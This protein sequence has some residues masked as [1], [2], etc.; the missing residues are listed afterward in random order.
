MTAFVISGVAGTGKSTIAAA[1]AA[2]LQWPCVEADDFHPP[3]NVQKMSAGIPLN[4][5]DRIDWIDALV[6]A[7]NTAAYTNLLIA[8]SALTRK[9]RAQLRDGIAQPIRFIYLT[10]PPQVLRQR[11]LQRRGHF[12]KA[13]MLNSQL[14]TLEMAL[15]ARV[16]DTD[17]PQ[18][19]V[20]LEV[21]EYV[22]T[23]ASRSEA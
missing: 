13:D 15:D 6:R 2:R 4:D 14:E 23:Q 17:R 19:D 1:V 16:V 11:L 10:A 8:C 18:S 7:V 20:V 9:V 3:V 21:A 5:A 22:R 12:M